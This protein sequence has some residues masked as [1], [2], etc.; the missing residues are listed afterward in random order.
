MKYYYPTKTT[1]YFFSYIEFYNYLSNGFLISPKSIIELMVHPGGE[2]CDWFTRENELIK[3]RVLER[4]IPKY[5][6]I[7]FNEL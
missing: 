6:I 1:D 4:I 2:G 5:K 3:D 7:N